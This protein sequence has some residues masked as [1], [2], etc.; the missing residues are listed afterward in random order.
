[1]PVVRQNETANTGLAVTTLRPAGFFSGGWPVLLTAA[2]LLAGL[3]ALPFIPGIRFYYLQV[4]ILVFWFATVGTAWGISGGYGGQHSVG[5]AAFVGVG[6]YSSTLLYVNLGVSPW[7]GMLVG[8]VLAGVL[9]VIIGYPTFKFGLRGDYF[10]LASLAV[11]LVVY[12]LANGAAWLTR[13]SQGVPISY[14]PD[15]WLF[16]FE[17]RRGFYFVAMAMWLVAM[18]ISYRIRRSRFGFQ[19][20]AVRDD[21]A[22]ASRGGISVLKSKL[23]AFVIT[24]MI[25]AAAGTFYAQFF[26]FIDPSAVI[27]LVLSVQI[28]IVA[29][30]G[31]MGSFLGATVGAMILVP[32]AEV[33][34][35][36]FSGFTGV[37]LIFYGLVLVL[38]MMY[39][40][41]GI[42]GALRKSPRWR[43]VIGW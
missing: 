22:A 20:L 11:G 16:Q 35:I 24:A 15:P 6:A 1:M 36:Q 21:E 41:Y 10:T 5:N 38:V 18:F 40:P 28:M 25:T 8:I 17:D 32:I 23:A 29:A 13:G 27:G 31:G 2:V 42:L 14:N 3:I 39:M 30:L 34:K 37:D 43:K 19:V 7:I 26:L 33:F 9:A 12:E 4:V